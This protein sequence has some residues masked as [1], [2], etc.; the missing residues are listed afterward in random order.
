MTSKDKAIQAIEALPEDATLGQI[1]EKL[2]HLE[3]EAAGKP[4]SVPEQPLSEGG[5]WDLLEQAAGS[6]E[7]P[8]DW[9]AEHDHYLFGTPRR[10]SAA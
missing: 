1:V 10:S 2:R 9:A 8:P 3:A 4:P 5:V 7:M 6:V